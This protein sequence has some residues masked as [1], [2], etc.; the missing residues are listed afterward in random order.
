MLTKYSACLRCAAVDVCVTVLT[1]RIKEKTCWIWEPP[2]NTTCVCFDV[3]SLCLHVSDLVN[4]IAGSVDG[5]Q[6]LQ[7]VS[8]VAQTSKGLEHLLHSRMGSLCGQLL[9]VCTT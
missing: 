8:G 3:D 5:A 4:S 6:L 9:W 1:K 2:S 7:V